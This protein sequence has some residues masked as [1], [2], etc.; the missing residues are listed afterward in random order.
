MGRRRVDP[1]RH[2]LSVPDVRDGSQ[3]DTSIVEMVAIPMVAFDSIAGRQSQQ[4]TVKV[5]REAMVATV[6]GDATVDV[7]VRLERPAPLCG[8]RGIGS[9]DQGPCDNRTVTSIERDTSSAV[10]IDDGLAREAE[11]QAVTR[12]SA[13]Q[14]LS[15]ADCVSIGEEVIA[16]PLADA[17]DG[18]LVGHQVTPGVS[19]GRWR[20]CRGTL[21]SRFYHKERGI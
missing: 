10:G 2:V 15:Y 7:A 14:S 12:P 4:L 3:V 19:P 5:D 17:W 1:A 13:V 16:T 9:V 8:P 21:L 18:T 11:A 6:N 20:P